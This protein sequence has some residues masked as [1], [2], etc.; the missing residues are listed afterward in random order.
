MCVPVRECVGV[1]AHVS[2]C[3]CVCT[4]A[5]RA[6]WAFEAVGWRSSWPCC[7]FQ[8]QGLVSLVFPLPGAQEA[9][10]AGW[11]PSQCPPL[12]PRPRMALPINDPAHC[13]LPP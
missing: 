9:G 10:P 6:G 11:G 1:K 8:E 13:P 3:V 2:V 7:F 4:R 5:C 12:R